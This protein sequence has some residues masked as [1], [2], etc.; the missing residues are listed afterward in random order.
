MIQ[1]RGSSAPVRGGAAK[2]V[3]VVLLVVPFIVKFL[4]SISRLTTDVYV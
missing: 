1:E 3:G 2:L 4:S